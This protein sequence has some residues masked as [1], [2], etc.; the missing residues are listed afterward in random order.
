MAKQTLQFH[1]YAP[2]PV[3]HH[4][5]MRKKRL[6]WLLLA[7][8][9]GACTTDNV[10]LVELRTDYVAAIE[11]ATVR[12]EL[13]PAEGGAQSA[14]EVVAPGVDL[15]T[16][17]ARVAELEGVPSGSARLRVMLFRGDDAMLAERVVTLDV[18]GATAVTV[19]VTRD[20]E[21][22]ACPGT[23]D[24]TALSA[25]LGGRCVDPRCTVETPEACGDAE[26]AS[27]A[28]CPPPAASCA[29]SVCLDGTCLEQGRTGAC[30]S[31]EYCSPAL[32]CLSAS[33]EDA[34]VDAD[35]GVSD[36]S[37]GTYDDICPPASGCFFTCP[38]GGS[39]FF[40]SAGSTCDLRADGASDCRLDCAEGATC[41]AMCAANGCN[42][43]PADVSGCAVLCNADVC[44]IG[45]PLMA[46]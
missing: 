18:D 39:S 10:V 16:S 23:A 2:I 28:D 29:E 26:C 9:A 27:N 31:G 12:T 6:S 15:V 8:L 17:P 20:C 34:A 7:V 4:V 41:N 25:C 40:C 13:V 30:A 38:L 35:A 33:D 32:G 24:P 43:G 5:E 37:I 11:V 1:V 19:V 21:E 22:V 45:V 14:S 36:G 3:G 46:M 42:C 44:G